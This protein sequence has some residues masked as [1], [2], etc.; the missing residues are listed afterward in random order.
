MAWYQASGRKAL[1]P[2]AAGLLSAA[3]LDIAHFASFPGMPAWFGSHPL[4]QSIWF[5]FGG[6]LAIALS[7]LALLLPRRGGSAVAWAFAP[8]TLAMLWLGLAQPGAIPAFFVEG[9][10]LTPLKIA[11]EWALFAAYLLLALAMHRSRLLLRS[12][13]VAAGLLVLAAGELFFTLYPTADGLAN[14]IGHAYKVLGMGFFF[15]AAML[16]QIVAPYVELQ[17]AK[18]ARELTATQLD[19]LIR[20]APD[21]IVVVDGEGQVRTANPLAETLFGA[22]AGGLV[23]L[24]LERLVPPELRDRHRGHRERYR[25]A[26]QVRP[27]SAAPA[28]QAQRLDGSRF[29]VDI[30]LSPVEWEGRSTTV[31]FVRD[32]TIRVEQMLRL[33]WL[34][35]HD[36]LT[37]LPNRWALARELGRRCAEGERGHCVLFDIDNLG[38]VNDALGHDTGDALLRAMAL[39]L[40]QVVAAGDFLGRLEGDKFGVVCTDQRCSGDRLASLLDQLNRPLDLD[41]GLRLEVS[42]TAGIARSPRTGSRPRP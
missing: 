30:S 11:I 19:D 31:A 36:P 18:Q 38:R 33:D 1:L 8:L 3:V 22:P 2:M 40:E 5:W 7:F 42:V 25:G 10:G 20:G 21:G 35:A 39:R 13:L 24:P 6:R 27:M 15:R 12:D 14:G 16:A 4:D 17:Q 37:G 32:A 29:Y 28:L 26:P 41:G 34:A 9:A 23:G